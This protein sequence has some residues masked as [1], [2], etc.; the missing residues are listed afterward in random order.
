MKTKKLIN[1]ADN[2]ISELIDG[3]VG[4]HPG[5]LT[6]EGETRRAVVAINGPRNGKVGIAFS[7]FRNG[8]WLFSAQSFA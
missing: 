3:T 2:I 4:A 1:S 5:I 8:R 6:L 7:R